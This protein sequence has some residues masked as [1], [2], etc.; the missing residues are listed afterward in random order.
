MACQRN[1][2][3]KAQGHRASTP[4][5]ASVNN[6]RVAST[7]AGTLCI[8]VTLWQLQLACVGYKYGCAGEVAVR[9]VAVLVQE[10]QRAEHAVPVGS[11][12]N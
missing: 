1:R 2:T 4:L 12:F 11:S 6:V 7:T 5:Q 10:V 8:I 3:C 9:H